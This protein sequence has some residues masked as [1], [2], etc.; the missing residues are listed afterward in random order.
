VNV[1]GLRTSTIAGVPSAAEQLRRVCREHAVDH[2]T[3]VAMLCQPQLTAAVDYVFG[4]SATRPATSTM[5]KLVHA[6]EN[7]LDLAEPLDV[8]LAGVGRMI[9]RLA[10]S[11][12]AASALLL[13]IWVV[14]GSIVTGENDLA[15]ATSPLATLAI[16]LCSLLV[17]ALLEAA[18]IGAVTL[19]T[20]D[21]S[22]LEQSHPRVFRLH[23]FIDTK[24]KLE[25][26]LAARQVGVVLVVFMI[27]ELTRTADLTML[28]GTTIAIPSGIE[29]LFQIGVP[30]ALLVL[31]LGQVT[32]QIVTARMPA[33]M[34]NLA[35]MAAAFHATRL[36]GMLGLAAPASWLVRW[37][38]EGD[39]IATAPRERYVTT[40]MD[41][42]GCGIV[43][44]DRQI[45]VGVGSA[46]TV[47][48]TTAAFA[49]DDLVKLQLAIA[50]APTPPTRMQMAGSLVSHGQEEPVVASTIV[51]D[52]IG[53]HGRMLSTAFA[54]RLGGYRIGDL[55]TV[56]ATLDYSTT[57]DEDFVIVTAPTK[58]VVL[59]AVLE[60]PPAPLPPA[61]LTCMRESDGE[62][63]RSE[64]IPARVLDDGAV[65][66]L[67]LVYYPD[68][69]TVIRLS[70]ADA[71]FARISAGTPAVRGVGS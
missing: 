24:A 60:F 5:R 28:P 9:A 11:V 67:G 59:R 13:S 20:A 34:M 44:I 65:E 2:D 29:I 7:V 4:T 12:F 40:M 38:D 8:H 45:A 50:S 43:G 46:Q 57:I 39:R 49:V 15:A 41:V 69:G 37:A 64:R 56:S 63:T 68:P 48:Q 47:T 19:S 54:P 35:P 36:I 61:V 32:P 71:E 31:V 26:Y 22:T 66:F 55:L 33:A 23:R 16:L 53:E 1:I 62:V 58:L 27:S 70:W 21:V 17:L 14:V 18:H 52:R 6:T 51:E 3:L 10:R 25:H 42:E 30:G